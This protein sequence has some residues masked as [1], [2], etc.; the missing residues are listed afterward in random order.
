MPAYRDLVRGS[1]LLGSEVD[2]GIVRAQFPSDRGSSEAMGDKTDLGG[3]R[4][5][6]RQSVDCL[7]L[8]AAVTA[9]RD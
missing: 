2:R 6:D 1:R 7:G 4:Q 3:L 9:L 8:N 5:T